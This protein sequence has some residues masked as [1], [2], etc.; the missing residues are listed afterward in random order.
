MA[1]NRVIIES[2]SHLMIFFYFKDFNMICKLKA[3]NL[4]LACKLMSDGL[5]I[6]L[7]IKY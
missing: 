3:D 6:D 4:L 2:D 5:S 1:I 7:K